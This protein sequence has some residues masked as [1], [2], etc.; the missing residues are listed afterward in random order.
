MFKKYH[1]V[2]QENENDCAIACISTV[3]KQNGINIDISKIREIT[4][5]SKEGT[6]AKD[7]IKTLEFFGFVVKA[8]KVTKEAFYLHFPLPCIAHVVVDNRLEH[9]IVIHS[10]TKNKI[11]VSDPG[12]GI[13]KVTPIF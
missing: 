10:I 11:I 4:N 9:Y 13:I 1:T 7:I 3:L 5:I 12:Y 6:T 2:L 8:V